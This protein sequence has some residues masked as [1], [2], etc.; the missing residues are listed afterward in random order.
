MF[1]QKKAVELHQY[2]KEFQLICQYVYSICKYA[3]LKQKIWNAES[4][5]I[6]ALL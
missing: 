1:H 6:Y 3:T 5:E 2:F 4:V